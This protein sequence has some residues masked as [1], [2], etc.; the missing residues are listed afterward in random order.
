MIF[1]QKVADCLLN[2]ED[3]INPAIYSIVFLL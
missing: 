3:Q 2:L 1:K